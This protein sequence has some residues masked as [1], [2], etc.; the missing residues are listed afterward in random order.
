MRRASR[1]YQAPVNPDA[2]SVS[3]ASGTD[4]NRKKNINN[5]PAQPLTGLPHLDSVSERCSKEESE[6]ADKLS[7]ASNDSEP[8]D[9]SSF[10]TRC[11]CCWRRQTET[12]VV[13]ETASLA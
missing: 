7:E 6:G 9:R 1:V 2:L 5:D 4:E 13:G 8:G 3:H 12:E 11:L 10:L